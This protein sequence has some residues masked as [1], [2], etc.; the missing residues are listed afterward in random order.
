MLLLSVVQQHLSGQKITTTKFN[1][2]D[3]PDI[4]WDLSLNL[5][6][7]AHQACAWCTFHTRTF[8]FTL[9]VYFCAF[10]SWFSD[11][12]LYIS[13]CTDVNTCIMSICINTKTIS[14]LTRFSF[15][16]INFDTFTACVYT[17]E[18]IKWSCF[19]VGGQKQRLLETMTETP[20]FSSWSTMWPFTR[21]KQTPSALTTSAE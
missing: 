11:Y 21:R 5:T 1:C 20:T 6:L 12:N 14:T 4:P 19:S 7:M 9:I 16:T 3:L 2:P 13:S 15:K 8:H 10:I 17:T 18:W